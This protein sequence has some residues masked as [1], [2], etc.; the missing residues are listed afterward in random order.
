MTRFKLTIEYDGSG[1]V[2]W[3]RQDNGASVQ[4]ALEE[5]IFKLAGEISVVTGAGRTDAGVHAMAQ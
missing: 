1:F 3:Q 5:A 2:G 4:G